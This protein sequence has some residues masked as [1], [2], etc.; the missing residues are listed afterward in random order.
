MKALIN[1]HFDLLYSLLILLVLLG[2]YYSKLDVKEWISLV[3]GAII[4]RIRPQGNGTNNP[5]K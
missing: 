5:Q 4:M 2:F 1:E 3:L